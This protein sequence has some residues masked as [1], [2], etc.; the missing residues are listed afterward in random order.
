ML[1]FEE[2]LDSAQL[3]ELTDAIARVCGGRA[4]VFAGSGENWNVCMLHPGGD[5][6]PV[7]GALKAAFATR[8]GGKPGSFQGTVNASR[9]QIEAFFK[10]Q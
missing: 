9:S 7:I 1:H 3:R 4:A 10:E 8:G 6:A 5:L 2:A